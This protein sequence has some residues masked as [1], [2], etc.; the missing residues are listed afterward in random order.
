M[1]R[2]CCLL[3]TLAFA[4]TSLPTDAL[5]GGRTGSGLSFRLGSGADGTVITGEDD[6]APSYDTQGEDDDAPSVGTTDPATYGMQVKRPARRIGISAVQRWQSRM[7]A[8]RSFWNGMRKDM[9]VSCGSLL[10]ARFR[11]A[12]G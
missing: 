7:S 4:A 8:W 12:Q 5:A 6:D 3:L 2:L 10:R 11:S 9:G 1:S